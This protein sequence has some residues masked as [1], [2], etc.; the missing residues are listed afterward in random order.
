MDIVKADAH[1]EH[2]DNRA[3]KQNKQWSNKV[4]ERCMQSHMHALIVTLLVEVD[5]K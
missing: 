5:R 1:H 3:H 4:A 2:A